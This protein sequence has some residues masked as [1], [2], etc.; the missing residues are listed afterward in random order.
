MYIKWNNDLDLFKSCD[1]GKMMGREFGEELAMILH[2]SLVYLQD[3]YIYFWF[4]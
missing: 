1:L 3:K 4:V 2:I